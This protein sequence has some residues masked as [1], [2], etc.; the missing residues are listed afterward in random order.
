MSA[1]RSGIGPKCCRIWLWKWILRFWNQTRACS[2]TASCS[3]CSLAS[4]S[5]SST[6]QAKN[7]LAWLNLRH[8]IFLQ[9]Q[10][11]GFLP[12]K[13]H[14]LWFLLCY[15]PSAQYL[16]YCN[17]PSFLGTGPG[18]V[19][20]Q[21]CPLPNAHRGGN[22]HSWWSACSRSLQTCRKAYDCLFR[23]CS[24]GKLF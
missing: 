5:L 10:K 24:W 18:R 2:Y 14:S 6:W 12:P 1:S 7:R 4:S 3:S 19:F 15:P 8:L 16:Q 11:T 23:K 17:R 13:W 9:E 22:G 21:W 20:L